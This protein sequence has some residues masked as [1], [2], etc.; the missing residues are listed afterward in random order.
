MVVLQENPFTLFL[1]AVNKGVVLLDF[2]SSLQLIKEFTF[3]LDHFRSREPNDF[4]SKSWILNALTLCVENLLV[5]NDLR[6]SI[7]KKF[8]DTLAQSDFST[9]DSSKL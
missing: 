2:E 1:N 6:N 7:K 5:R 9:F 8:L 3:E 4:F